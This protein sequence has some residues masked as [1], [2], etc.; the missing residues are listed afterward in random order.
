MKT[1]RR[2]P[3][4][5]K[6]HMVRGAPRSRRAAAATIKD[7][8]LVQLARERDEAREQQAATIEIL[9]VISRS[10]T[11]VQPVLDTIVRAAVALCDSYDA[12]I[13]LRDGDQLRIAA[14]HGTMTLDFTRAPIRPHWVA[15]RAVVDRRPVHVHDLPAAGE[16]F[17]LG[18]D[19]ARRLKQRT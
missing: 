19:I 11:D 14:H 1:K 10:P 15:G 18:S 2:N 7:K 6:R 9:G 16:E 3:T 4:T 12:V 5:P 8:E 13:L 17:P